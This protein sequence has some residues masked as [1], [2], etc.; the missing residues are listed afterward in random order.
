MRHL[1]CQNKKIYDNLYQVEMKNP[2]FTKIAEAYD[3]FAVRVAKSEELIP[4]LEKAISH[5]GTAIVDIAIDSFE[6]V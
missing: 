2:D 4:A 3:L 6:E 5:K 1:F